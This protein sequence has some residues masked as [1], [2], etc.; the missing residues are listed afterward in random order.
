MVLWTYVQGRNR[1]ADTEN[2][3]VGTAGEGEG[4]RMER[5]ALRHTS[6]RANRWPVGSSCVTQGAQPSA[7]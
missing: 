7:L 5:A 2:R 6:P 1:D 4:G 3:L